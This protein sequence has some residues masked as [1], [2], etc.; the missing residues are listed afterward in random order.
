MQSM[1]KGAGLVFVLLWRSP[2]GWK[3]AAFADLNILYL[4]EKEALQ[5]LVE[6]AAH[7]EFRFMPSIKA[8]AAG[9]RG[10]GSAVF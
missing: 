2:R 7:R 9:V 4:P 10:D 3:M 1:F 5:K 6:A 8:R